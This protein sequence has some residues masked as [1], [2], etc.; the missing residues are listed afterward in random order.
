MRKQLDLDVEETIR[1]ALEVGDERVR[2]FVD[3]NREFIAEETRT[4]EFGEVGDG[5][6][7]D[8]VEEW[9]VEGV[10]VTIGIE[11]L[12]AEQEAA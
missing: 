5:T 6:D 1:T 3:D 12:E 4:A 2:G 7:Y 10:S 8:L 11:R 9:D